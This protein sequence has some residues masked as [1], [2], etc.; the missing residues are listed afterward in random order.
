MFKHARTSIT[1][2]TAYVFKQNNIILGIEVDLGTPGIFSHLV[3]CKL[4]EPQVPH[5][6][7]RCNDAAPT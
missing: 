4:S 2:S 1:Y 3:L 6:Q 5:L 7:N